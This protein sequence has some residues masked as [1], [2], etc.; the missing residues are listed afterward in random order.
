MS[1][2]LRYCCLPNMDLQSSI[3]N[4]KVL[5]LGASGFIGQQI[6]D[7]WGE[8]A[9]GT[10]FSKPSPRTV[11]FD[12]LSTDLNSIEG[13][14]GCSHAVILFGE[15]NPDRCFKDPAHARALN[16]EGTARV[17]DQCRNLGITPV[18]A[19]SEAVFSGSRGLYEETDVPDPILFYGEL[20]AKIESY[21]LRTCESFLLL[22]FARVVGVRD[23]DR[24]LFTS[25]LKQIESGHDQIICARDQWMSIISIMDLSNLLKLLIL[26]KSNGM[27]HLSDGL[28]HNRLDLL[29]HFVSRA[30]PANRA[31][32]IK[33]V[34]IGY[35]QCPEVRPRDTSLA[36]CKVRN[37][38]HYE[39]RSI[40]SCIDDVLK[41]CRGRP[42]D[43]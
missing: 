7:D 9:I 11:Y 27:F 24:S 12:V 4:R 19:S 10:H 40:E 20:K 29:K 6:L 8:L 43:T 28:R 26:A 18:F 33:E 22:R 17:I 36:S 16:V 32:H 5:I 23:N 13:V 42:S 30:K 35:F 31:I 15:T 21:L 38:F 2:F 39:F 25:W 1:E 3:T 41:N 14:S 34:S 37:M